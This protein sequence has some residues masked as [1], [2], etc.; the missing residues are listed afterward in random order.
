MA[1]FFLF[2]KNS[3]INLEGAIEPFSQSGI[4]DH[5]TFELYEWTLILFQKTKNKY[6]NYYED[7]CL[8]R[9]F[10]CGTLAYEQA[11]VESSIKL[12]H[13]DFLNNTI[14][15]DALLGNYCAL[16]WNGQHLK[17]LLDPLGVQQ[18][19]QRSDGLC[20]SSSFLA[21]LLSHG[22]KQ[23]IND[24]ALQEKLAT[25]YILGEDTLVNG[26]K[27]INKKIPYP[28]PRNVIQ[29]IHNKQ[30]KLDIGK[31]TKGKEHSINAQIENLGAYF[32]NINTAF[33]SCRRDIGLSSGFDCRLILALSQSSLSRPLHIHSHNTNIILPKK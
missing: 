20:F 11:S 8:N 13:E 25:G 12:L 17:L 16:F 18:V 23:K 7:Q 3:T 4:C 5:L 29:L 9:T 22:K 31:H 14:N 15:K 32:N 24:L 1:G 10:V 27:K 33:P 26:I 30:S 28:V 19:F 21:L 6:K 2:H